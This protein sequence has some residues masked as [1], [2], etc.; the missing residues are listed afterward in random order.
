MQFLPLLL[1]WRLWGALA[2]GAAQAWFGHVMYHKGMENVQVQFEA[3]KNEQIVD[4]LAFEREVLAK[5]HSMQSAN[6][7]VST[8]Y[9]NLKSA[10]AVAVHSLDADRQRLLSAL[11][12]ARGGAAPS[13][14]GPGLR[15]DGSPTDWI[16][17]GCLGRYEEVAGSAD[18]LSAQVTGLQSYIRNVVQK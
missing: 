7:L 11:E 16:L 1:N 4:T 5:E 8:N 12:A 10:T 2:F 17:A 6:Q 14:T 13:D 18:A 15:P 3:Y 9:E